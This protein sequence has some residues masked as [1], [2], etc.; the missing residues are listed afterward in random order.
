MNIPAQIRIFGVLVS[1]LLATATLS[2][3]DPRLA[4]Q[5][6]DNG[7]Y[8]KAAALY[9]KLYQQD[10][11]DVYFN[12]YVE[13]LMSLRQYD[14]CEKILV[15]EI[16]KEPKKV[17]LYVTYGNL[18]E[19]MNN[20][21]A[22]EEQY[23]K[24]VD[25]LTADHNTIVQ[26]ASA[27]TNQAKYKLAI[28][29]YEKGADLLRNKQIFAFNLAEL[30]RREDD[31]KKMVQQYLNSLEDNPGYLVTVETYLQRNLDEES[32]YQELMA[33]LYERIQDKPQNTI[34]P[35][36]LIWIYLQ[37]KDYKNAFRQAKAIDRQLEENGGR[38]FNIAEIA[39]NDKDYDAAI[40]G[41]DYVI[42]EKGA[43]SSFYIDAKRKL[44]SCKRNKLVQGYEYSRQD[45][46]ILE[47]EYY[48]F[49]SEL[50]KNKMTATIVAEL[51]DL[52]AFYLNDLEKATG[53]L[54]ELIE[55]PGIDRL[56]QARAK[57][58][59]GDFYLMQDEIWEATLLYSQVDK[60]FKDDIMGHEARFR[61]A[62]LSYYAGDF[63]W[64]QSQFDVLKSSTSK[65]IANDALD[66]SVF[67][68]DN[69]G[70]DTSTEAL[71]LYAQ[72]ELLVFQNR[73]DAAFLKFDTIEISF[74][75]HSLEDDILYLEAQI[76]KKQR[77]YDKVIARYEDIL[78]N[79]LDG[80]RADNSLFEMAE[81][82]ENQLKNP[83]KAKELYEKLFMEMSGST[84][85][86]EARKRFRVLRGDKV[87]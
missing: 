1:F 40:S 58:S 16:K 24:A 59:L 51:A 76:Y 12:R 6:Y 49:L 38:V 10:A 57:I 62:K 78:K 81:L 19:R 17:S 26:L 63:E 83:E 66:L 35:E 25:K 13:C 46:L 55:Y 47:T 45:L 8:E 43:T 42:A 77:N 68:M 54:S 48:S 85:A 50:G 87:R 82:Y 61:N 44:L 3:Q 29:V 67:I 80:I 56:V 27:F 74:P 52:E 11:G 69:M 65:L 9:E 41:Y 60:L 79:H 32:D 2:A 75:E 22:A 72:A 20:N 31:V 73:F 33:Q 7:E 5:Y 30:Y 18:F 53:L 71:M 34:Y 84:Y 39:A 64:A 36:L 14:E 70:L 15:K 23:R 28:E 4:N 37:K 21:E 86:V